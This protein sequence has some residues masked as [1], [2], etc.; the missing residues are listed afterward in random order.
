MRYDE[1]VEQGSI[2]H[3]LRFTVAQTRMAYVP[4]ARHW[5]SKNTSAA[6]PPMGMRVRL[7]ASTN[8]GAYPAHV[9]VIMR[10]MMKYGMF[11]ADNGSSWYVSGAPDPRWSDSEL[12]TLGGILLMPTGLASA[13]VAYVLTSPAIMGRVRAR[14]AA[15]SGRRV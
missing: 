3:A 6:L 9:Q 15:R 14:E 8:I 1:V 2:Q 12:A 13:M 7:K 4:P 11:V 5:A 10:A